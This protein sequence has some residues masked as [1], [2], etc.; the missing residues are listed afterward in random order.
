MLT[1][2]QTP[3]LGTPLV[4]LKLLDGAAADRPQAI[5]QAGCGVLGGVSIIIRIIIII[6]IMITGGSYQTLP[7]HLDRT[8]VL[9]IYIYIYIYIS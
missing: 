4:P 6:I 5:L 3:F 7:G 1:D 9:Y 2:V 8:G